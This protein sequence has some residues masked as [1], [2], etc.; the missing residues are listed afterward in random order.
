MKK[1]FL[2]TLGTISL[3]VGIVGIVVPGLPTTTFLLIAAA[4]YVRS[5]PKLYSWLINHKVYGRF[6]RDYQLHKAI[7]RKHK[8]ISISS[9]WIMI[10]ASSIF[11]IKI[12]WVKVILILCGI[13]GTTVVLRIKT[14]RE[15]V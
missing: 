3:G 4:C 1:I 10:L 12:F 9:M 5:S 11:F 8:I 7:S 15:A 2:I 6:I 14:L 13:I